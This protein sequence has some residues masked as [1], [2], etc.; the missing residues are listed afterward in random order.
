MRL[1]IIGLLLFGC[2]TG[3]LKQEK[4]K[5]EI[6]RRQIETLKKVR[7][8]LVSDDFAFMKCDEIK[9][10]K[11]EDDSLSSKDV[12]FWKRLGHL[13]LREMAVQINGNVMS[14]NHTS[15]GK[16]NRF[17]AVVFNCGEIN[18]ATEVGEVGMCK[19]T[20]ERIFKINYE[21]ERA[22]DVGEEILRQKVRYHAISNHFKTFSFSDAKYSYTKKE[23]RVKAAFYKCL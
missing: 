6:E 8:L 17:E 23:F 7:P 1:V 14:L 22:R 5:K 3:L 2:S 16:I 18:N 20:E 4:S 15:F 10:I 13:K 21:N 9:K 12:Q 19:P 11:I